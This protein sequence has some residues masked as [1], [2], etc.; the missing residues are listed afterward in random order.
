MTEFFEVTPTL[1]NYWRS[2]VLFGRNVASYKFALAKSLLDFKDRGNDLVR[3]EELAIPF[4]QNVCEHLK[5]SPK[6]ATSSSSKFLDACRNRNAEKINQKELEKLTVQLGFVNVIDAFHVVN[7]GTIPELFFIDERKENKGIRLTEN[8]FKLLGDEQANSFAPEVEARW[9]LVETAW[10]LNI[11]RNHLIDVSYEPESQLITT[12]KKN[13]RVGITSCRHALNGYQKGQCF[14]CY[15]P[16]SIVQGGNELADVDHFFPHILKESGVADP[17]DG[18]WN[19]VLACLNCNRGEQGKF[20]RLPSLR[21]L[22]KLMKRNNYLISSH[23]PLR[24]TLIRQTG[25][26]IDERKLFLQNTYN[27]AKPILIHTWDPPPENDPTF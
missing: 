17:I 8:L 24:E 10:E 5:H 13:R 9:N 16:I 23:H 18:V 19:L 26:S 22:K 2:I 21:L 27:E 11:S 7:Q 3:L 4:A 14:Y 1:D 25:P 20:T 15:S 12:T 6:Q